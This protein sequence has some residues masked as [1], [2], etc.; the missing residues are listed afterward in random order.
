MDKKPVVKKQRSYV[1]V[2]D[3]TEVARFNTRREARVFVTNYDL[4]KVT[5]S[6][7]IL[8]ELIT[9]TV[10]RSY[11]PQTKVVLV[12]DDLDDDFLDEAEGA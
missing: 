8:K 5:F 4:N 3:G 9:Q 11:K 6:I 2:V 7:D 12:T 1:I 10:L